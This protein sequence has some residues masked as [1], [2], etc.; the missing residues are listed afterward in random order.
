MH[1]II[2][3]AKII[4]TQPRVVENK[5]TLPIFLN[6]A[7][8]LMNILR[9]YSA[10]EIANLMDINMDLAELN[11]KRF[12]EW[13]IDL[14]KKAK[15]AVLTFNGPVFQKLNAATFSKNELGIMQKKLSIL[16]GLYGILRPLDL[17]QPYRLEMSTNLNKNITEN[18]YKFWGDKITQFLNQR[19]QENNSDVLVN[20]AS[21]EYFKSIKK[22]KLKARIITINFKEFVNGNYKTIV[23]YTKQARGMMSRFI[24]KNNILN[25]E[26]IKHF[27]REGYHYD[28]NMSDKNEWVFTR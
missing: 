8:E 4:N 26:E 28:D 22:A 27:D 19:L 13:D 9:R 10:S 25:P 23:I 17:I 16:S 12:L 2:S 11:A 20:L 24:I 21:G 5:S 15:P 7:G 3:P 18:L 14:H 6:E 1:I